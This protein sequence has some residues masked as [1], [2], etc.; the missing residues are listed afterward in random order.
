MMGTVRLLQRHAHLKRAST[1]GEGN[2]R[3][4]ARTEADR[5]RIVFDNMG[6]DP[7][8]ITCAS[9]SRTTFENAT[10]SAVL[11]GIDKRQRWLLLTTAAHIPRSLGV[12][13]SAGWNVTPYGVDY[14]TPDEPNLTGYSF[15]IGAEKGHYALHDSIGY[16]ADRI[17]RRT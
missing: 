8:R 3:W 7:S 12:F 13:R 1:G 5:A 14:R 6:V 10:L 11:P 2:R 16:V 9:K 17:T 15:A 4:R